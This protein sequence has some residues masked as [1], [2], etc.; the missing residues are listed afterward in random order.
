MIAYKLMRIK[1]GKLYP[2]FISRNVETKQGEWLQ[3]E[4][5][6]T[7]GFK[8]RHGWHCTFTPYAPHLKEILSNGEVRTWV[9]IEVGEYETYAR[10]ES[11]GGSWILAEQIKIIKIMEVL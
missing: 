1:Q 5:I 10:P 8:T 9:Q 3:A 2:L 11:Q 4:T 6:P 7:K